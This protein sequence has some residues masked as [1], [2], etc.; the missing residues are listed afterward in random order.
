MS[1]FFSFLFF[2]FDGV[3]VQTL[4]AD[5]FLPVEAGGGVAKSC[6]NTGDKQIALFVLKTDS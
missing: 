1:F 3:G 5:P 2:F 4:G 6:N